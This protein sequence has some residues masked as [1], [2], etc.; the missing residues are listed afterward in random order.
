MQEWRGA[1][2]P[3]PGTA[4]TPS[5]TTNCLAVVLIFGSLGPLQSSGVLQPLSAEILSATWVGYGESVFQPIVYWRHW[6][7]A[8]DTDA[9]AKARYPNLVWLKRIKEYTCGLAKRIRFDQREG[10]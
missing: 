7:S 10:W 1:V 9:I 2:R 3:A 5:S 4:E 6:C 8:T